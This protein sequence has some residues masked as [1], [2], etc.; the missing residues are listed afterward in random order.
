MV[1]IDRA[2][3]TPQQEPPG[4]RVLAADDPS[5][6]LR[7]VLALGSHPD[8]SLLEALIERCAVEADF[9][10]RDMLSWALL[11][12][13]ADVT[14]PRLRRELD[15]GRSQA[16]SQA[17]HTLSKIK[18]RNAWEWTTRDMLRDPDDDVARTAWRVAAVLVPDDEN[19]KQGLVDELVEQ[20]GRGDRAL[21]L[22]LSRALVGLGEIITPALERA[23]SSP[24]PQVRAHARATELLL[25]DPEA[26]F[27]ASVTEAE[28][29]DRMG[30]E[31]A[32]AAD[33]AAAAARTASRTGNQAGT[34]T[35]AE[36]T[37]AEP[38]DAEP[39]ADTQAAERV[40]C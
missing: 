38:T 3:A 36:P 40:Q 5:V 16:R 27:D 15:S 21:R 23:G 28:R 2:N 32:V 22:S 39:T 34:T 11:R 6:R 14:L 18:D 7:A 4:A 30:P 26:A 12:L 33:T 24:D 8:P 31:R 35:G 13:P 17:L 37:D 29:I 10:V 19:E 1:P 20:L 9:F 25:T